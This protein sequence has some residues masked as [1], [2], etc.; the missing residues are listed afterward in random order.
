MGIF[1]PRI[2]GLKNNMELSTHPILFT[3]K[4]NMKLK[5]FHGEKKGIG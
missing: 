5:I 3:I 4:P 1:Q 2:Y